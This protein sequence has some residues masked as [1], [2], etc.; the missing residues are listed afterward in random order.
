MPARLMCG[1]CCFRVAPKLRAAVLGAY[2]PGQEDDHRLV[3]EEY[4]RA[5]R[6]AVASL[7]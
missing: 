4:L 6:A 7:R 3:T 5:M 1:A 2:R